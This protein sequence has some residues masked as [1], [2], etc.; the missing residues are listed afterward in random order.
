MAVVIMFLLSSASNSYAENNTIK[1]PQ[2]IIHI[3]TDKPKYVSGDVVRI[4]GGISDAGKIVNGKVT[5]QVKYLND[6]KS[7]IV[8]H[9]STY[10]EDGNFNYNATNLFTTE[11][12]GT[13]MY[14]ISASVNDTKAWS[15]WTV[16]QVMDFTH[17]PAISLLILIGG[18]SIIGLIILLIVTSI[19]C[20]DKKDKCFTIP[21]IFRFVCIS[22]IAAS[23]I[24]TFLLLDMELGTN[25]PLGVVK[26]HPFVADGIPQRD[27]NEQPLSE[28]TIHVDLIFLFI[29]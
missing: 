12:T 14:N 11:I 26:R 5:I 8:A 17:V 4:S 19:I 20:R 10:T 25:S 24:L 1:R 15:S 2:V 29:F 9:E 27:A 3:K 28:W 13:G 21:E 7:T 6:N 16:I 23:P 22:G 18:G